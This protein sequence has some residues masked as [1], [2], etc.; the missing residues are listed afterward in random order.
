MADLTRLPQI[1]K[2][3]ELPQVQRWI[4][5]HG[6]EPV[7][8][9][10]RGAVDQA[11]EQVREGRPCPAAEELVARAGQALEEASRPGLRPLIN[12]TGV[13]IHTN[14]G[15]APLSE[16]AIEAIARVARSYSNLEYDVEGGARGSRSTHCGALLARL[17]GAEAAVVVNNCAAAVTLMLSAVAKGREVII[18]RGQLVEIGGGF[19]VPEVMRQSGAA[20]VEVGTTNRTYVRDYE[21][22]ITE[23]TAALLVVHRSNFELR[24]FVADPD[25]RELVA[26]A[27]R[28]D[29]QVLCDVGSGCLVDTERYGLAHEPKVQEWVE[30]GADGVCF[31]GDKLVGG[32]Q[33][34]CIVGT[35][36]LVDLVGRHPLLRA[37]RV[38]KLTLAALEATLR[39]YVRG[40]AEQ[41]I[42][43]WRAAAASIQQL[44]AT[45]ARWRS[46]LGQG[47][48]VEAESPIGG[49]SLP[50]LALP[51]RALALRVSDA[52]GFARA[53]RAFDPPVVARIEDGAVLLDP[54]T[55]QPHEEAALLE[56]AREA[57]A[58]AAH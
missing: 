6:R 53:L 13:L 55:V 49:G 11:R 10:L 19:R 56:A 47:E 54:R 50:G 44:E 52:D 48:V 9:A 14:L 46:A 34:G 57:L 3:A 43:I 17:C 25:L 7:L 30:A 23:R 32:P 31:S 51:T 8:S 12:A 42:P 16:E 21:E 36:A 18:S 38:D 35:Q 15:R 27:R 2:L 24:G 45:A 29:L 58:Q 41:R 5:A 1:G 26:L 28:K 37:L 39:A 40:D 22:A 20:L 33:A 4:E